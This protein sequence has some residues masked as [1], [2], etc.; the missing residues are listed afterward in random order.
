M[1][2]DYHVSFANSEI[3]SYT[4]ICNSFEVYFSFC[5][6]WKTTRADLED[7]R[8]STDNCLR[9]WRLVAHLI[10]WAHQ[11]FNKLINPPKN[12]NILS[13]SSSVFCPRAG[14]SLQTQA[15]RLQFCPKAG[16]RPQ[17]QKPRLQFYRYEDCDYYNCSSVWK[18]GKIH[19]LS[20]SI[21]KMLNDD[22]QNSTFKVTKPV[23]QQKEE[24]E[25]EREREK[26]T[27]AGPQSHTH[28]RNPILVEEQIY[29]QYSWAGLCTIYFKWVLCLPGPR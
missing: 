2:C 4:V 7:H 24:R 18:S 17:T 26:Y 29:V 19:L 1:K 20:P 13:S 6:F 21:S 3:F 25:R 23:H 11:Y 16:P 22:P 28:K 9:Q 10:G 15:P 27:R 12:I 8:W 14:L 5:L